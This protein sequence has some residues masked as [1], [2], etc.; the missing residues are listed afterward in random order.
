MKFKTSN[1]FATIVITL[2]FLAIVG[3]VIY[4]NRQNDDSYGNKNYTNCINR[5]DAESKSNQEIY[6]QVNADI[7]KC[8]RDYIKSQGYDDNLDCIENYNDPVCNQ[9]K[10]DVNGKNIGR[11]NAEVNGDNLCNA[12]RE[13]WLEEA[14]Y[15]KDII[16]SIDCIKYLGK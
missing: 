8:V 7:Q 10:Y 11:Y 9:E 3:T 1:A 4:K 2:I 5:A 12:N 13:E 15:K 6:N 16:P 14:G